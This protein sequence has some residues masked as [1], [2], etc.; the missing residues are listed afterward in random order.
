MRII[1]YFLII[2]FISGTMKGFEKVATTSFQFLKVMTTA[3]AYALAGAYTTLANSSDAVFWNPAGLTKISDIG[4]SAGY[5]DWFMDVGHFSFSA[6]Y[7]MD[8]LGTFGIFGMYSDIGSIEETTVSALGYVNG[9]YNPGLT[10]KTFSPTAMVIGLSYARDLNDR[11]TFGVNVKY[12]REDLIYKS[13]GTIIFDGG[14]LYNTGFKSI[15]LG[16]SL[17][18]FGPEVK[19]IDKSYP[20]PQTLSLGISTILL[21]G[22]DPLISSAGNHMLLLAYDME[23][24]RDYGQQHIIGLEYSFSNQIF[25]RTGY[26]FNGDQEGL[27]AGAGV[28][29]KGYKVDYSYSDYGEYLDSV[30]RITLGIS[31]N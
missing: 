26:K 22:D 3:R 17:R 31:I 1:K 4:I 16:A 9:T 19:Y 21:G 29:F 6:A 20:L 24:P 10:G 11:F 13:A 18:N 5:T 12:A 7:N 27:S 14:L 2:V 28:L 30:H 8:N 25:L 23:Q 15:V